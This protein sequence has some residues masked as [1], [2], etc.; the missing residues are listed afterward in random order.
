MDVQ[1]IAKSA[2]EASPAV[3]QNKV[4]HAVLSKTLDLAQ[5]QGSAMIKMMEQ[6][7]SPNLGSQIDVKV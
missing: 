6:S 4:A 2:Y 3:L 5:Q 1:G 7:V